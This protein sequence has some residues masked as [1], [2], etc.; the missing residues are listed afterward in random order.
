MRNAL[1]LFVVAALVAATA[2]V[3]QAQ[4]PVFE[5]ASVKVNRSGDGL[6][7]YPRLRNGR[8]TAVNTTLSKILQ[9]AYRLGAL[10]ITG[11][12]WIDSDRFDLEGKSPEGGPDSD[13]MP[14]LQSLLKERFNL[15]AHLEKKE[16]PVYDLVVAK[17][18]PKFKR[19]DPSHIPP[20]LPPNGAA[21][22][23]MGPMTM[24]Q[25]AGSLTSATGRPVMNKTGLDGTYFCA[26]AFSPLTTES[27]GKTSDSD[28]LD[29]FQA[30]Q[31][32]LG[33]KL[34]PAKAPLDILVVD[35]AERV[36]TEN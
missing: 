10:Q 16:V 34:E 24:I 29:I 18:G 1:P 14:M 4:S 3:L 28:P 36:P 21:S 20:A 11:P 5:A 31:R 19:L 8:L 7:S 2:P 32:Q 15:S 6:S 30:V 23:I 35:R 33:L 17:D 22:M 25:L 13:V 9:V 27:N 12:G 26:V